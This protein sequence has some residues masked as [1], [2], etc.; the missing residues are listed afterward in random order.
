MLVL[1]SHSFFTQSRASAYAPILPTI[2]A[3]LPTSLN[4]LANPYKYDQDFVPVFKIIF[5]MSIGVLPACT[6]V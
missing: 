2:R 3:A 4:H 6:S 5:I 1:T